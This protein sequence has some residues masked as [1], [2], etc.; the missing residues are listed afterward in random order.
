MK[1]FYIGFAILFVLGVGAGIYYLEVYRKGNVHLPEDVVM[2]SAFGE[3]VD[4]ADLPKRAR[5]VEFMYTRCPDVCPVTTLEMAKLK[6]QLEEDGIWGDKVEFMTITIDPERDTTET[7]QDYA[8]RFEVESDDDG[9]L[10]LRG[11]EEDTRKIADKFNFLYRDPGDGNMNHT[12]LVYFMDGSG[13]LLDQ[14]TMGE[15]FNREKAYKRIM[16]TVR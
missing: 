8:N 11:S 9:W 6:T 4:F 7:M 12:S 1:K 3:E 2:E 16:R 14:F 10:F 15:D 5:I 13:N